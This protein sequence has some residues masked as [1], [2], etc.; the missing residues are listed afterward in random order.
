VSREIC[1]RLLAALDLPP[2]TAMVARRRM[3][4]G[5]TIVVRMIVPDLLP[6]ERCPD[7]FWVSLSYN[8]V[9]EPVKI[10]RS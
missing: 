3:A 6:A 8:Q 1:E 4:D 7:C 9:A 5:D 10:G 2:G